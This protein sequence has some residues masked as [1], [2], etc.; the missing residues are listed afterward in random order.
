MAVTRPFDGKIAAG[1]NSGL[2]VDD[3]APAE[4]VGGTE[5]PSLVDKTG[6]RYTYD[7]NTAMVPDGDMPILRGR[8]Y[9]FGAFVAFGNH[10]DGVL[11]A[12]GSR[13]GGHSLYAKEGTL[14]YVNNFIGLEEQILTSDAN[15][16]TEVQRGSPLSLHGSTT[17]G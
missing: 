4:M 12:N 17:S 15:L 13:F 2:P 8:H 14:K 6:T 16:P 7:A 11:F 1:L 10:P 5:R 3:R 9:K